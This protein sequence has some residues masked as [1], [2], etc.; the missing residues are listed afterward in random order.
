MAAA[1]GP[2]A[3]APPHAGPAFVQ[4][5]AALGGSSGARSPHHAHAVLDQLLMELESTLL[6]AT[7]HAGDAL[8]ERVYVSWK[9]GSHRLYALAH[10]TDAAGALEELDM[11][12]ATLQNYLRDT[13]LSG[14]PLTSAATPSDLR[15][16]TRH[17]F[18]QRA[19]L[20]DATALVSSILHADE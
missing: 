4:A 13:G 12:L 6:P 9:A 19:R 14:I 16:E 17:A 11:K 1:G 7:R 5:S 20:S 3:E 15:A 8:L 18:E 10:H 2:E